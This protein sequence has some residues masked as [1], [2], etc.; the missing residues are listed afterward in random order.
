MNK[1]GYEIYD[2]CVVSEDC[3]ECPLSQCRHDN[4][5]WYMMGLKLPFLGRRSLVEQLPR[6]TETDQAVFARLAG[7][8]IPSP[9]PLC[10]D[11]GHPTGKLANAKRCGPC[12]GVER[13][14]LARE[15]ESAR[16]RARG[17]PER[18]SAL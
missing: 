10:V 18:K 4:S 16:R 8:P 17:I 2:P 5:T 3:L 1:W 6:Y 15:K 13:N 14:R 9:V 11:C 12:Q 7:A